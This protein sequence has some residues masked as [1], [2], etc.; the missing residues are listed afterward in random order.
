MAVQFTVSSLEGENLLLDAGRFDFYSV[1]DGRFEDVEAGV[2][3]VGDELLGFLHEIVNLACVLVI[4][5]HPVLAGLLHLGHNDG[6]LSPMI[7]VEINHL[8]EK[9]K[10]KSNNHLRSVCIY[11]KGKSQITSLLSTKKG[12]S[13]LASTSRERA[14]GPAVPRGSFSWEKVIETPSRAA[15]TCISC[16]SWSAW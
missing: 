15:S 4:N 10:A 11:L 3:L 12:S 9:Q 14:R 13:S 5:H 1:Q 2:D 7:L 16:S 6:P 8:P